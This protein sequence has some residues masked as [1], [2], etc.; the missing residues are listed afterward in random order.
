MQD[1]DTYFVLDETRNAMDYLAHSLIFISQIE[2]NKYDIKWFVLAFHGALYSFMLLVLQ[3][4]DQKLIYSIQPKYKTQGD[5]F[6]PY[7]GKLRSFLDSYKHLKDTKIMGDSI[8]KATENHDFA[9]QE[10]NHKLRNQF[11][12]FL[13]MVW[14]AEP[15]YPAEV[16]H[17]LLELLNYCVDYQPHILEQRQKDL[18][19]TYINSLAE[20]L[21]LHKEEYPY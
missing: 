21:K 15:W 6:D 7:D 3:K 17:Q 10:L 9:M 11:V 20:I 1:K 4:V 12:H 19:R 16:C 18:A 8:F 14:G 13:P 5:P 2:Q